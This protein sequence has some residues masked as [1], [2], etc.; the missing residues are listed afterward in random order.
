MQVKQMLNGNLLCQEIKK[1]EEKSKGGIFLP[2]TTKIN[3]KKL[4]VISPSEKTKEGDI[5]YTPVHSGIP[6]EEYTIINQRDILMVE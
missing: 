6:Y 3:Y 4:K 5:V 1:E 2:S